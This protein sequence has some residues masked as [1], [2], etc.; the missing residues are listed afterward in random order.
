MFIII[1][2][3]EYKTRNVSQTFARLTISSSSTPTDEDDNMYHILQLKNVTVRREIVF[4][5]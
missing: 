3:F 4:T 2:L 5:E 1:S